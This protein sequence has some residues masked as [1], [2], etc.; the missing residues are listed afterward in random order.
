MTVHVVLAFDDNVV[1]V[2]FRPVTVA[3]TTGTCREICV[4][5]PPPLSDAESTAVWFV[6]TVPVE[7]LKVAEDAFA[8]TLTDEGAVSV[9]DAVF[10]NVTTAPPVPAAC[11]KVT[12][13]L[14]L[15]FDDKV[16]VLHD[17]P[18]TV[19]RGWVV[20]MVAVPPLAVT[21]NEV[22]AKE[23]LTALDT[24]MVAV[25]DAN[26]TDTVATIPLAMVSVV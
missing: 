5:A 12:V 9:A 14:V 20:V 18:V 4:D 2:Q 16:V 19:G 21:G 10:P 7:I 25:P 1:L 17:K 13:Q 22:P 26:P 6:D 8:A 24:P 15:P 23:A 11:D 3:G